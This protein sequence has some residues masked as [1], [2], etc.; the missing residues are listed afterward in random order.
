MVK[1]SLITIGNEILLGKTVN[2][3]L[4][5]I[6]MQLSNNGLGLAYEVTI[7]DDQNAIIAAL[8]ELWAKSDVV[9]TSGGLGPTRDDITKKSIAEFFQTQLEFR[10]DVWDDIKL[11]YQ[12][13]NKS[14]PEIVRTQAEVPKGFSTIQNRSGTAP[15]LHFQT[16]GKNFF[17]LPGVPYEMKPMVTEYI[18]PFLKKQYSPKEFYCKTIHTIGILEAELSERVSDIEPPLDTNI[19]FL[20]QLGKVDI[21]IYGNNKNGFQKTI[22]KIEDRLGKYIYGYDDDTIVG[23]CHEK[24]LRSGKKLT[25]AESCT[26]G[27]IQNLFTNNSGSSNYFAGGVISYSNEAKM[28]LLGVKESTLEKF[29][30]VSEETVGEMLR[31]VRT[32]FDADYAIAVSGIAG[33]T[34]GTKEKPVGLVFIGVNIEGKLLVKKF[35]FSGDRLQVKQQSA[36]NAIYLLLKNLS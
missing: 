36:E 2:T 10:D 8:E 11:L 16:D 35:D 28:K 7:P 3:N 6:G 14:I 13:K 22:D 26:G 23:L 24:L 1:I 15:G 20:P 25:V 31:G 33:P 27:L 32:L 34:G 9:I 4:A 29:G 5:F 30:A 18:I 17:A 12:R 19:A 21:R